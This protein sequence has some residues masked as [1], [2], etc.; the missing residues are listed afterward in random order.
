M[1]RVFVP[2]AALAISSVVI[3]VLRR[4][5]K[6]ERP[7]PSVRTPLKRVPLDELPKL[8]NDL[9]IRAYLGQPTERVPVWCMRQAGRHLPEFRALRQA[10]YDFFTMCGV[11]ELA[12]EV[13]LQPVRRY[14]VDAAIIFSD[15]L[16]VPQ[17]MGMEV[18][19]V[20]GVGPVLPQPLRT[21]DDLDRL[22]E[23]PDIEAT[24][25][26]NLDALNLTRQLLKGQVPLIGF[27]GG[28]FTLLTY[29]VEGGPSKTKSK[30]K[31]WLYN[32]P[33]AAHR[34]LHAI[35]DVCVRFLL[36]QHAAGAQALQVFES[37]G[38]EV[39]T[40]AHFYEFAFPYMAQIAE[41]VKDKLP[42]VPLVGFSKGTPY[43]LEALAQTKYDCLGLDWTVDPAVVRKQ[44]GDRVSLQGNLD[45]A[46]IYAEPDTIRGEVKKMLDAFGTQKYVA[47]FGHGCNPDFDPER[48][49]AFVKAVQ[50]LSLQAST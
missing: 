50:Q 11:P 35:T 1:A 34:A 23:H 21:P 6:K 13:T 48:V 33:E 18:I 22:I 14:N 36:E 9:L 7:F 12:A 49:D 16:V 29:M 40:Q 31:A 26:Y 20:P 46:A 44:V 24:L 37:V 42:T 17:A 30:V 41:R 38:A 10:G 43:A 2:L 15:I 27:C 3:A 4:R 47:N 25:G 45:S 5:A 19:M 39:L 32:H 28:P 8:K